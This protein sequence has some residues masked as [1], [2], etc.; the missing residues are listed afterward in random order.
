MGSG[1]H[2]EVEIGDPQSC[3][4]AGYATGDDAVTRV[5]R[6]A[7][8]GDAATVREEFT[9]GPAR[10][11]SDGGAVV[12]SGEE[13]RDSPSVEVA[14][15]FAYGDRVVYHM[16]RARQ[17]C[18]CEQV[19]VDDCVVRDVAAADGRLQV[20]FLTPDITELQAVLG[21]LNDAYDEV[22][23]RR[24]L[25]SEDD[26]TGG[27][28]VLVDRSVLTC[29]QREV[30]ATAYRL[31]Y[32]EHPRATSATEVASALDVTTATFTEHLAA[33]QRKLLEELL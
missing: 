6:T 7:V 17:G 5:D 29:R 1:I 23:V 19:E 8:P 21:R 4:V 12:A 25:R 15:R 2:A 10:R 27:D 9:V 24:L 33:A 18:V 31:G 11:L 26:A 20:C 22:H 32:F 3:Q 28:T 16:E 14:E 13:D 30:L